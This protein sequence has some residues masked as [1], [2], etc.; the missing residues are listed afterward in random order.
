MDNLTYQ[1]DYIK[2][3]NNNIEEMK[4]V[5]ITFFIIMTITYTIEYYN[6]KYAK[7]LLQT[8]DAM[9]LYKETFVNACMSVVAICYMSFSRGRH[10]KTVMMSIFSLFI[11]TFLI[12]TIGEASGLN[13]YLKTSDT[14]NGIGYYAKLDKNDDDDDNI[15]ESVTSRYAKEYP[16]VKAF[17]YSILIF[18]GIYFAIKIINI[19]KCT[20]Y[21]YMDK[22]GCTHIQNEVF[23]NGKVTPQ[24]GFGL[25]IIIII[26][27]IFV[28]TYIKQQFCNKHIDHTN[29]MMLIFGCFVAILNHIIFQ[30][31]GMYGQSENCENKL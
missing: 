18:A 19:L 6:T 23:F 25:E 5:L 24:V 31:V 29:I 15:D 26:I 1:N 28:S 4:Y 12:D 3:F 16:F 17:M 2:I 9:E 21:G 22:K 14:E 30:Y 11:L 10:W 13:R 20:Y 27:S 7:T 8:E